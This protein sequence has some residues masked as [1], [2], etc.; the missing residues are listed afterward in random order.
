MFYI[1]D[2]LSHY[3]V[4]GMK[5]GVRKYQPSMGGRLH[6][7]AAANYGLNERFYRKVGN[8]TL[9]SMNAAART[10]SLK[11]ADASDARKAAK[12]SAKTGSK[13]AKAIGIKD[14]NHIG[15]AVGKTYKINES[16]ER[17]KSAI[18]SKIG[19][20]KRAEKYKNNADYYSKT[21]KD[22]SSGKVGSPKTRYQKA[23]RWLGKSNFATRSIIRNDTPGVK[24]TKQQQAQ[25]LA[26]QHLMRKADGWYKKKAKRMAAMKVADIVLG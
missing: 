18:A 9:A 5:W 7:L 3:G 6:R 25:A 10:N 2:E 23:M 22:L 26:E 19:A 4:K 21:I 24:L 15:K 16:A 8:N 13:A 11:K 14:R 12:A 1:S 17:K 20:K